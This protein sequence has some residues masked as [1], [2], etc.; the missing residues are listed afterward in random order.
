[1]KKQI[2]VAGLGRFGQSLSLKLEEMGIEVLGIDDREEAVNEVSEQLTHAI[3]ADATEEKVIEEVG[4]AQFDAVVCA[5]GSNIEASLMTTVL[6]KEHGAKLL[7][8]K[9]SSALHG[10]ILEKVGADRIVYPEREVAHRLARDFVVPREFVEVVPLTVQHS[11]FELKSPPHFA[12]Q[13][14]AELDLR[15]KFGFLVVA[16]RRGDETVVAPGP[17]EV[18]RRADLLVVV[19]DRA[20]A[21][22]ALKPPR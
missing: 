15:A 8:A 11:M 6:F 3:I 22:E 12:G 18:I 13:T 20:R 14:L 4:V 9:A 7:V 2:L 5:I 16:V 1:M 17:D 21:E 19:G 10:R